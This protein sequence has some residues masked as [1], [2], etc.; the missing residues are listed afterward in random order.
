M[1]I[2][3]ARALL[4]WVF[5]L[6]FGL[7]AIT[8]LVLI[9]SG[10]INLTLLVSE[11]D[12]TASLSRFQMLIMTFVVGISLYLIVVSD[13]AA[14]PEIPSGVLALLGISASTYAV[15]KGIQ[16]AGKTKQL[17]LAAEGNKKSGEQAK[18]PG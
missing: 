7:M 9:W 3:T 18:V 10:K 14:F 1:D 12:G 15:S 2:E 5:A 16:T 11:K 4:T 17:E 6:F 13:P 8:I